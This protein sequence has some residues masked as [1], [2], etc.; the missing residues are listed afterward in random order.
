[1]NKTIETN[2]L[3][4]IATKG[5]KVKE[6]EQSAKKA[7]DVPG[8]AKPQI[9]AI[10]KSAMDEPGMLLRPGWGISG[11]VAHLIE[12]STAK[13]SCGIT[14][15]QYGHSAII[16]LLS[17][18][19]GAIWISSSFCFFKTFP[20]IVVGMLGSA[21]AG[22]TTA[23][24]IRALFAS[25]VIAVVGGGLNEFVVCPVEAHT[26]KSLEIIKTFAH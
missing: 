7:D 21:G 25:S 6:W 1:M 23:S 19:L 8:D 5:P 3:T 4:S 2:A 14:I 11:R 10:T 24:A 26:S 13:V 22:I 12:L 9:A 16:I 15:Y 17:H 18:C 20:S